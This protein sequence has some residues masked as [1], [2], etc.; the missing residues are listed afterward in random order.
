MTNLSDNSVITSTLDEVAG[1]IA[2]ALVAGH[3]PSV[4]ESVVQH[5]QLGEMVLELLLTRIDSECSLVCKRSQPLSPFQKI[6]ADKCST[7]QW[8]SFV[9]DLSSKAP[10]LLKILSS[11]ATHSNH[12]NKHK[13]NTAHHP[14]ICMAASILLKERNKDMCG[15]QSI[16]SSYT[17]KYTH[18]H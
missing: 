10:T 7:F 18:T 8:S 4:A 6:D 17:C 2:K 5:K 12:R 9:Q 11:I 16:I 3:L 1:K 14:G 15:V 13:L